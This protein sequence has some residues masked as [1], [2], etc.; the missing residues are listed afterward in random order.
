MKPVI[1]LKLHSSDG[2]SASSVNKFLEESDTDHQDLLYHSNVHWLSLVKVCQWVWKLKLEIISCLELFENAR[3]TFWL[4]DL[5]FAVDIH[6]HEWAE[7]EATRKIP[8]C[9]WNVHN[10][11]AS[12]TKLP[13]FSQQMPNKPFPHFPTLA[14]LKEA[15]R[16]VKNAW[17]I[18]LSVLWFWQIWQVTSADVMSLQTRCWNGATG[19]TVG[20]VWSPMW[21][22]LK[23]EVQTFQTGW[24]LYFMKCSQISK[25]PE[26]GREDAG[27]VRLYIC[28]L[29]DFKCDE[30]QQSAPQI[31]VEWWTP[32]VCSE[33]CH[34]ETNTRLQYTGK[35]GSSTALS[36][37]KVNVS[38]NTVLP[39]FTFMF[40][41]YACGAG[42]ASTT[43]IHIILPA[44]K[45]QDQR[46]IPYSTYSEGHMS[47]K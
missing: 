36:P 20:T 43:C 44:P 34:N 41:M 31:P 39:F 5:A 27:V 15:R 40:D 18:L 13:L 17:R 2:T 12:R 4:R 30:H 10:L 32:Q 46:E 38:I 25:H 23:G 22:C 42:L 35:I 8:A 45:G 9:A 7:C 11:R 6:T 33:N 16:H 29:T 28:V 21:H 47:I 1:K 24:L 3:D 26:D 14:M 37:L 19:V